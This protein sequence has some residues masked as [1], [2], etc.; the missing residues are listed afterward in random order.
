MLELGVGAGRVAA[1]LA[2]AGHVVVGIDLH[3][4]A[5]PAADS[6][7]LRVVADMAAFA[8]NSRFDLVVIAD[9][10]LA[11]LDDT[12]R[13]DCLRSVASHLAPTGLLAFE[14]TDHQAGTELDE[15]DDVPVAEAEGITLVAGLSQDRGRRT[16]HYRRHFHGEGWSHDDELAIR[17]FDAAAA[18]AVVRHAGLGLV[19]MDVDGHRCRVVA[20]PVS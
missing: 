13:R 20:T 14:V 18:A 6:G 16:T 1:A 5:L 4:D 11:L 2:R 3:R 19:S 8:F 9:N 17:S 7:A 15:V 12:C 10:T